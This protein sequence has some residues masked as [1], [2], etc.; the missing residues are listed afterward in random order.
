MEAP[1]NGLLDVPI[2]ISWN[3]AAMLHNIVIMYGWA[4]APTIHAAGH[5]DHEKRITWVSF[6]IHAHDMLELCYKIVIEQKILHCTF[7]LDHS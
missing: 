5:V 1:G 4:H 3:M 2:G 7:N 6:S